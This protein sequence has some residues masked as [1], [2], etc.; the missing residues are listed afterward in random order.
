MTA[1]RR[2]VLSA[3]ASGDRLSARVNRHGPENPLVTGLGRRGTDAP[4]LAGLLFSLCPHAHAVAAQRALE[5]AAGVAPSPSEHAARDISVLS[6]ALAA[7]VWRMGVDW[8]AL[9]GAP[10]RLAP[11]KAA[12]DGAAA[13][14]TGDPAGRH[15]LA[16]ALAAVAAET[17]PVLE[18][19]RAIPIRPGDAARPPQEETPRALS[20][21]PHAEPPSDLSSW[22]AAQAAHAHTVLETLD[23]VL[24]DHEPGA[25][26]R[27]P[28]ERPWDETSGAGVGSALTARG[29]L[30]HAIT[31]DAGRIVAWRADAPTDINFAPH[32]PVE[33]WVDRL[34]PC[35]DPTEALTWLVAAFDPCAPC[36]VE[37]KV[38]PRNGARP[39]EETLHA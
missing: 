7:A 39:A 22:F 8:P 13:L 21:T 28:D 9:R 32:G 18:R 6:E 31:L 2:Y 26:P 37:V 29:R 27:T 34:A 17:A 1:L 36:A 5:D 33:H 15:A 10:P 20:E 24:A 3:R 4:R 30:R 11:V 12:R 25:A 19:A 38:E 35:P 23:A 16:D 14:R